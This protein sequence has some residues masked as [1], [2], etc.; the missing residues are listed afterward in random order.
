MKLIEALDAYKREIET[1]IRAA[2]Y[3]YGRPGAIS[4]MDVYHSETRAPYAR[5][6]GPANIEAN[7][8]S[9]LALVATQKGYGLA[10]ESDEWWPHDHRKL[11]LDRDGKPLTKTNRYVW[12]LNTLLAQHKELIGYLS[13]D[14]AY[15]L[16]HALER[17]SGAALNHLLLYHKG[18]GAVSFHASLR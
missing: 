15:C 11:Y 5:L 17:L 6:S 1:G 14:G 18:A 8:V 4:I 10:I 2:V 3:N 16:T 13:S 12:K 9:L 7:N